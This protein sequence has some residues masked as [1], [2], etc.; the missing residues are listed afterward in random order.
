MKHLEGL[1]IAHKRD[2]QGLQKTQFPK[3][4]D[5]PSSEWLD[6]PEL[7]NKQTFL[8]YA[9]KY[10]RDKNG[11]I[12]I[13]DKHLLNMLASQLEIYVESILK[14]RTDGLV[15]T[16]NGGVTVGPNPCMAIA[17]KSLHRIIQLMKELEL[18]PKSRDGYSSGRRPSPEMLNFLSGP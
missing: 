11:G 4:P 1:H 14:L 8:V 16:F 5:D 13:A 18:S 3:E 9:S 15:M 10:L 6:R 2:Q 12:D 7:W 17:D